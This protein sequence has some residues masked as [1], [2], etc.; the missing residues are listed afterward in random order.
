[1]GR[2]DPGVGGEGGLANGVGELTVQQVNSSDY[3]PC[4]CCGDMSRSV[5]G[6]VCENDITQGSYFVHWTLNQV[7]NHGAHIDLIISSRGKGNVLGPRSA[8]SLEYRIGDTGP[9]V[10]VIDA[11]GRNHAKIAEHVL[12]REDVIGTLLAKKVFAICDVV[13]VQDDRLTEI[14]WG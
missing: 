2:G 8:I 13:L 5:W 1:M 4:P 10:M 7:E 11:H 9:S 3:G 12:R 6:L 14:P